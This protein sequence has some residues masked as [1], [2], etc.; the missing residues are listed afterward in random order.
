MK[1]IETK[2]IAM[3]LLMVISTLAGNKNAFAADEQFTVRL[4]A[5][6]NGSYTVSP[7]VPT[8][9]KV[10][11]GTELTIKA[12]P[13]KGYSMDCIYSTYRGGMW[14]V[15]SDEY[16]SNE[17]KIVVDKD[18]AIGATF[19]DESLTKNIKITRDVVYAKPGKKALKYDVFS[20]KNAKNLPII[21]IIHGGGWSS[22]NEDVMR[23]LA[24]E[25]TKGEKY[26]VVSMDYRWVGTLDG[27]EKP[28]SMHQLIED[29]FGAIAHIR[30]HAKE[31]G[32]NPNSIGVTGDSA[33]GHLSAAA[34]ILCAHIGSGGFGEKEGV[35]EYMPT[36]LPDGKTAEEI[37]IELS[38]SIKAAAPSYGPFD[39]SDFAN[40]VTQKD[41][42]YLN[43]ISPLKN[44]PQASE[45]AVPHYMVRGTND[46]TVGHEAVK[47]YEDALNLAGQKV[48]YVLVEGASHAFFDWKPDSR[49][50]TTFAQ[51]GVPYAAEM[52]AFFDLYLY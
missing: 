6:D 1:R 3:I 24:I 37:K 46:R 33:G 14:G 51:Y 21:V 5:A 42:G 8:D 2:A 47:K 50:R 17:A 34:A 7:E 13:D 26:V 40:F 23:G 39:A 35:Y 11:A 41:P 43:A 31:Y 38:N 32:G 22:N 16:F 10:A 15:T 4:S 29:V 36:Y 9:G 48:D 44:I 18:M 19:F 12:K 52:K 27:D 20:P 45:R 30:E 28:N 25:L 49:T